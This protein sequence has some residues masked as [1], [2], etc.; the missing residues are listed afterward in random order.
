MILTI[1]IIVVISVI[2]GIITGITP[3]IHINLVAITLLAIIPILN[4]NPLYSAIII[5]TIAITHVF[6]DVIPTTFLGAPSEDNPI[7]LLPA[8][9]LLLKGKAYEAIFLSIVGCLFGIIAISLLSPLLVVSVGS[10]Y[11]SI[12]GLIPYLLIASI[13]LL[14]LKE[15][16]ILWSI[17][18]IMISGVFGMAA[19][20]IGIKEILFPM[21][22][23]LFGTASIIISINSKLKLPDQFISKIDI[24]YYKSAKTILN[25]LFASLLVGFLP[26]L[27]SAQASMIAT[28]ISKENDDKYY[29]ML[30][31]AINSMVMGIAIIALF[32]IN[33]ARNGA[34]A[35]MASI[36]QGMT[37]N[38]LILFIAVILFVSGIAAMLAVIISKFFMRFIGKVN[39]ALLSCIVLFIITLLVLIISGLQGLFILVISTSIGLLPIIKNISRSHLMASLIIPI[40]LYYLL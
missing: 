7:S 18:I 32:T 13:L 14:I 23:G 8:Q 15:K 30:I 22:S 38:H 28:S 12:T 5:I 24:E 36:L 21:F 35:I 39:Y 37:L 20:K 40:I 17:I 19:F 25:G 34:I 1:L 2:L 33:K 16:N 11:S 9:R 10:I 6:I 26:G 4:I 27:G 3:G 29:L 31:C